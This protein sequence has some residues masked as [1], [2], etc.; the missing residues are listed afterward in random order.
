MPTDLVVG[1]QWVEAMLQELRKPCCW[2][3]ADLLVRAGHGMFSKSPVRDEY[4]F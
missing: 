3:A 2:Y 4:I 1:L